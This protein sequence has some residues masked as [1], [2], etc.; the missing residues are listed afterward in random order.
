MKHALLLLSLILHLSKSYC[1]IVN[2]DELISLR[3]KNL[4]ELNDYLINKGW[5]LSESDDTHAVWRKSG[6]YYLGVLFSE[7]LNNQVSYQTGNLNNYKK[8]L[9]SIKSKGMK[10]VS[11]TKA[12]GIY[13]GIVTKYEGKKY[14]VNCKTMTKDNGSTNSYSFTLYLKQ[15]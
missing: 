1:Q 3:S 2:V 13:E 11:T 8:L 6:G 10:E 14:G 4:S 5:L 12:N 15:Q 7:D 9:T